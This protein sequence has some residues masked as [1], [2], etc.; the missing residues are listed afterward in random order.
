MILDLKM[1]NQNYNYAMGASADIRARKVSVNKEPHG[2]PTK[3]L[4]CF[5]PADP[6][7]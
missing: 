7:G 1:E 3:A 2:C 6:F 5:I 4:L